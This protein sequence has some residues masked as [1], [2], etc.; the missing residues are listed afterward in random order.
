M[1]RDHIK[2]QVK[3]V[4]NITADYVE[5]MIQK[6]INE[7]ENTPMETFTKEQV[8]T[9]LETHSEESIKRIHMSVLL[10]EETLWNDN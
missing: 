9:L 6:L 8:I 7:V 2:E 5:K 4:M 1:T 10:N 3:E